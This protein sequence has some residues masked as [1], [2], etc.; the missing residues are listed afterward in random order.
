[1]KKI[2]NVFNV[3]TVLSLRLK[4]R[5]Y[6]SAIA[7]TG[8]VSFSACSSGD[9]IVNNP[10]FNPADNTV[11]TEFAISLPNNVVGATRQT[12]SI[13]QLSEDLGGFRG[14]DDIKLLP[15]NISSVSGS[16]V[17]YGSI[18]SLDKIETGGLGAKNNTKVYSNTTIPVGTTHFLFYGK[19]IETVQNNFINGALNVAGLTE[20][21]F[22][23]VNGISFSPKQIVSSETAYAGSEKGQSLVILLNTV[24]EAK[25]ASG[26]KWSAS[27]NTILNEAYTNLKRLTSG[28]TICVQ[29]ALEDLYNMLE[30]LPS[31][32]STADV[33][34]ATAVKSAIT[35]GESGRTNV[36]DAGTKT[37][38]LN[39]FYTE[40]GGYPSDVNLPDGAARIT[41]N[42]EGKFVAAY[43]M[44][45]GGLNVPHLTDYVYPANLQYFVSSGL[46]V[47]EE[48]QS[49][50]Y[51]E[52]TWTECLN[53]YGD[54]NGT[55]TSSTQSIAIQNSIE[56]GVGRLDLQVKLA[57]DPSTA[58]FYD[59]KGEAITIPTTGFKLT[60][61]LI[62]NQKA[63]NWDFTQNETA[64]SYTIYDK[65][66]N[67]DIYAKDMNASGTNYTL[68]L[69]T[70]DDESVY[71]ALEFSNEGGQ[72]FK[73]ADGVIPVG[74][75]FYLTGELKVSSSDTNYGTGVSQTKSVFKQD[76]KTTAVFTISKG[77][78]NPG[79]S[80]YGNGFGKATNGLPDLGTPQVELG[81]SV[82]LSWKPGLN[83]TVD[84]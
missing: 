71:V 51:P 31:G 24:A 9:E 41:T 61:V 47:S 69:Q 45:Y 27:T 58:T 21:D 68:C 20:N 34:M 72:E 39:S 76:F 46:R 66:M 23:T 11:K 36:Y 22:T 29:A 6:V 79:G 80:D 77:S 44:N 35:T 65:V 62:G 83:I 43:E 78:D 26:N 57:D 8:A 40:N 16:S 19:A 73:G 50:K 10:N 59:S 60:G 7:L 84:I 48:I 28:S 53:L 33:D 14:M 74:G 42:T 12:G 67:T 15:F 64:H 18:I 55:V 81:L 82:D 37:L 13:V 75:K 25:D 49:G 5:P 30:N 1:M 54:R 63:V 3:G 56:Y 4:Y 32:T 52:R 38:T 17:K 70:K 2:F